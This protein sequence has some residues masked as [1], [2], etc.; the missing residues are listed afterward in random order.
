[1]ENI[2][3]TSFL[4]E[5][6]EK[7]ELP[8]SAYEK[9]EER[10]K[11]I[12]GWLNRENSL[13]KDFSPHIFSQ[14]SF[15][16]GTANKPLNSKE[17]YDLDLTCKLQEGISKDNYSQA[18]LKILIGNELKL[19]KD[20]RGINEEVE[21][22]KRCWRLLYADQ[23]KFHM[24][25][26]PCIPESKDLRRII[27]KAILNESND[28]FLSEV[29]S[30]LTV[31]ITDNTHPSFT[32]ISNNWY[33]S[34]PE[35]YA[36]WFESRMKQAY[37]L[38]EERA[39]LFKSATIDEIPNY[40]WKTPLQMCVQLL[41]RHRDI[42]FKDDSDVKPISIIITTLAARAYE[43]E[44]NLGDAILNILK[45]FE[46]LVLPKTPRISNPVNPAEDFSDKWNSK[47]GQEL[48]LEQNFRKWLLQAQVD[49]NKII[50]SKNADYLVEQSMEKFAVKTDKNEL[51]KKLGISYSS[52]DVV[53]PKHHEIT[54][55][56][57]PWQKQ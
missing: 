31:A 52:V 28:E 27:K 54:E 20:A 4:N 44:I 23:I 19:Y 6:A 57:K 9:A 3:E 11:D 55:K 38:L 51:V 16:L 26:V 25:I 5:I 35:G 49:F 13:C 14:G 34:N 42:M 8:G 33:I 45:R 7:L 32:K 21:E 39:K 2:T 18:K 1:M 56:S 43:G 22:K 40:K 15:R 46:S 30:E 41:K 24:D 53:N 36:R 48:K 37:Q 10:Y 17:E 47:E 50:S 29:V 12:G